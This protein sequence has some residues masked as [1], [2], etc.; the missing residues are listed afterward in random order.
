MRDFRSA[1]EAS[2]L[3]RLSSAP[4]TASGFPPARMNAL[5]RV[6]A[7][8][9]ACSASVSL[10]IWMSDAICADSKVVYSAA[11]L[12]GLAQEQAHDRHAV[13]SGASRV[14]VIRMRQFAIKLLGLG[15]LSR[16]PRR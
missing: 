8:V 6:V 1:I 5:R 3:S 12:V 11:A 2:A 16:A 7:V 13:A 4:M 14:V 9:T 10:A 15:E